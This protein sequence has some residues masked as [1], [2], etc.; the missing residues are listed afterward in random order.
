MPP[1]ETPR[2]VA[3]ALLSVSNKAGLV[4]LAKDLDCL[5]VELVASGGTASAIRDAGLP[6]LEGS[7]IVYKTTPEE[8][9]GHAGALL[10]AGASF[11][12]GC[13]GTNPKF[14]EALAQQLRE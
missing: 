1:N 2:K 13:C 14:I 9:A 7:E 3:R 4:E 5:G 10:R 6:V 12:G 11:I 8:F